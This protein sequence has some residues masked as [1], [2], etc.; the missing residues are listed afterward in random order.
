MITDKGAFDTLNVVFWDETVNKYRGFVRGFHLPGDM[1]GND[2]MDE[3]PLF[4]PDTERNDRVR[5]VRY[6]ESDDF[7]T[8]S[9]IR[10]L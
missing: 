7:I 1:E 9:R 10:D 6:I 5:D 3:K 2:P 4:L 8:W